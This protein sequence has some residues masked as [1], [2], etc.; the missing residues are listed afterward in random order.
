VRAHT[1]VRLCAH[2]YSICD[3]CLFTN[4][5]SVPYVVVC[6]SGGS[7]RTLFTPVSAADVGQTISTVLQ[8]APE[9]TNFQLAD[10]S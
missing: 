7:V 2:A 1:R 5:V 10:A 4:A 6:V 9:S 3:V 8:R